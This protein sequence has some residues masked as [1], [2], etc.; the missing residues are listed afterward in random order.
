MSR[1]RSEGWTVPATVGDDVQV[2]VYD[3]RLDR[4]WLHGVLR[5]M[6]LGVTKPVIVGGDFVLP[7][8]KED[9]VAMQEGRL[10]RWGPSGAEPCHVVVP[11]RRHLETW[12][13]RARQQM[14]IEAVGSWIT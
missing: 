10:E 11:P 9:R 3:T 6:P 13:L 1:L 14:M 7:P 5:E 8:D 12:L 2:R 4:D